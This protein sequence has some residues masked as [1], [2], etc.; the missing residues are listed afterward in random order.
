MNISLLGRQ[1]GKFRK[2]LGMTQEEL[3]KAVGVSTQAVSRWECGGAPDVALLPTI[4]ATL[5]VTIDALF[6]QG[7]GAPVD[8]ME[9]VARWTVSLPHE[10]FLDAMIRILWSSIVALLSMDYGTGNFL[11]PL[12]HSELDYNGETSLAKSMIYMDSGLLIGSY[13][14]DLRFMLVF[15]EPEEGYA[16][17]L[18][19][20]DQYRRFFE[21]LSRPYALELLLAFAAEKDRFIVAGSMAKRLGISTEAATEAMAALAEQNLLEK[22]EL[23]LENG[24]VD[25]YCS[26][27]SAQL[28]PLLYLARYLL[29]H[30]EIS[31]VA[32]FTREKP[33]LRKEKNIRESK[34]RD[35]LSTEKP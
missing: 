19:E 23:E 24:V 31:H 2:A 3:G 4:A 22:L 29:Q 9:M 10:E 7:N 21:V 5:H 30:G 18:A 27:R 12:E 32:G 15:P 8:I 20:N 16:A 35:S 17:F 14:K 11:G 1:I 26:K 6:G 28:I 13:A 25:A 34:K 33:W